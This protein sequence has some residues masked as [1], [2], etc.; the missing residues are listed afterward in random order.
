MGMKQLRSSGNKTRGRDLKIEIQREHTGCRSVSLQLLSP[1][2]AKASET[3][4]SLCRDT[5]SYRQNAENTPLHKVI[6]RGKKV[7]SNNPLFSSLCRQ[8][9]STFFKLDINIYESIQYMIMT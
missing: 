5:P 7:F 9:V 4:L 6:L 8:L 2:L 1:S 3:N